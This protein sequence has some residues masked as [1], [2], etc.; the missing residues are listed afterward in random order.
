MSNCLEGSEKLECLE[1][2]DPFT[3]GHDDG[4]D[5]LVT[6]FCHMEQGIQGAS[7]HLCL[8]YATWELKSDGISPVAGINLCLRLWKNVYHGSEIY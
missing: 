8:I 6:P 4:V 2:G 1:K 7:H 5:I 3:A